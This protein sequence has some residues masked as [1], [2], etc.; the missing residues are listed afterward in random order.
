MVEALKNYKNQ[1]F[2]YYQKNE[3]LV[4]I[5]VFALGF[6][7]D[8][9]T[10]GRIDDLLNLVQQAIYLT[11][12]GT[13]LICEIRIAL[14]TLT[15][16]PRGQNFWKYHNLV[17]HFLFGSLLS[18]YVIF[19]YTS[20][21]AITSFFFILLLAGLMLANEIPK[22][23][24]L[25]LPV[26]VILYSICLL[27]YFS[28]F[29]PILMGHV[30]AIPFWLGII[31]SI[32]ALI[33][34]WKMNFKGQEDVGLIKRHVLYPAL[35]VH[36][37]FLIGYYTSLIPPVP[38]AVKR[39]GIYHQVLKTDGQYI[40]KH[41]RPFWKIWGDHDFGARYGDKVNV[42][43][44]IFSPAR[45]D[46]KVFLLWFRDDEKNGWTLEDTIPLSILGGREEG[47]RGYA[48]KQFFTM[49]KWRVIVETSD[50]REVGRIG[51][52]ISP[53]SGHEER[54]FKNDVF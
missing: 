21:S 43:L 9:L 46:D 40:G 44:T 38:V 11:I 47:F 52:E 1:A 29:Y 25:G 39:I 24:D 22:I 23:Q 50:G 30:G 12:L 5:V 35:G 13:L 18:A 41:Q 37:F 36:L 15:L 8:L 10:L 32:G 26:R 6:V 45:F 20:A 27:S 54:I 19:Y 14:G 17:V 53:D 16:S 34:V 2:D 31:S 33:I 42:L 4:S 48:T 3:V 49:G 7:F 51:L 28:F